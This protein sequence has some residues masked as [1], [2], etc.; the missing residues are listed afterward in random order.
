MQLMDAAIWRLIEEFRREGARDPLI[1]DFDFEEKLCFLRIRNVNARLTSLYS[2]Y[3][4]DLGVP[5]MDAVLRESYMNLVQDIFTQFASSPSSE[6]FPILVRLIS[7][8][9][10]AT[11]SQLDDLASA[12]RTFANMDNLPT[13]ETSRITEL[14][15]DRP[16]AASEEDQQL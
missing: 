7:E 14:P 2:T 1:P 11:I 9:F 15:D 5:M 10:T 6:H 8:A 12:S 4:S 13:T 16:Q 3:V